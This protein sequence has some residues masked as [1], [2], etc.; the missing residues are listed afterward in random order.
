MQSSAR[1]LLL[2]NRQAI[3]PGPSSSPGTL[4]SAVRLQS[5]CDER[6]EAVFG[7]LDILLEAGRAHKE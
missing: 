1:H 2:W 7:C 6:V 4:N 3:D 5:K